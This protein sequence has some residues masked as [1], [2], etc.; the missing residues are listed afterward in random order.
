MGVTGGGFPWFLRYLGAQSRFPLSENLLIRGCRLTEHIL[1]TIDVDLTAERLDENLAALWRIEALPTANSVVLDVLRPLRGL[2]TIKRAE[3]PFF[4][5]CLSAV[6][7]NLLFFCL[8]KSLI[9]MSLL[10]AA[11]ICFCIKLDLLSQMRLR[12]ILIKLGGNMPRTF[13][14][15]HTVVT[16]AVHVHSRGRLRHCQS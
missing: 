12:R 14:V 11:L 3:V 4:P 1:V 15:W 9:R 5:P 7:T 2:V 6:L 10:K 16:C 13:H 8:E